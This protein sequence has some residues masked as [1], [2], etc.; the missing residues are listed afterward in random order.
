EEAVQHQ[1]QNETQRK[2]PCSFSMPFHDNE[3]LK[4]WTRSVESS[5]A[6]RA[7]SRKTK[8]RGNASDSMERSQV[9]RG[10]YW[11]LGL[12]IITVVN[13]HRVGAVPYHVSR[14][15]VALLFED[16]RLFSHF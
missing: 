9:S 2:S 11:Q 5:G 3:P 10:R 15:P 13:F 6:V 4:A 12:M 1:A 7:A 16:F 8:N 14:I